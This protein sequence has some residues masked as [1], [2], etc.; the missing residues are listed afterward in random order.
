MTP[1]SL[2]MGLVRKDYGQHLPY[3]LLSPQQFGVLHIPNTSYPVSNS[4]HI[5]A[6]LFDTLFDHQKDRMDNR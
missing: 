2:R 3:L 5:C 6:F 1:S 4:L